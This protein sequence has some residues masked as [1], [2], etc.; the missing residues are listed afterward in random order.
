MGTLQ[1]LLKCQASTCRMLSVPSA[2]FGKRTRRP[3]LELHERQPSSSGQR[4]DNSTAAP[5]VS[6][7]TT[8]ANHQHVLVGKQSLAL[9]HSLPKAPAGVARVEEKTYCSL[10]ASPCWLRDSRGVALSPLWLSVAS[11]RCPLCFQS[12]LPEEWEQS[13]FQSSDQGRECLALDL[14]Q[15]NQDD[16]CLGRK[17]NKQCMGNRGSPSLKAHVLCEPSR[18]CELCFRSQGKPLQ[19]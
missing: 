17:T 11:L 12:G 6:A 10:A 7:G 4:P 2:H 8:A 19:S 9:E 14:K 18:S 16:D 13:S 5:E 1:A 3:V 15:Q